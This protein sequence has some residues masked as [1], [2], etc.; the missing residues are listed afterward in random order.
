MTVEEF[1]PW[2][3]SRSEREHYDLVSGEVVAL[4]SE[5]AG[6]ARLKLRIMRRLAEAIEKSGVACEAFPNWMAVKV[7]S[8]TLYHPDALVRC[9]GR[10]PD[11]ALFV[12]DPVVLVDVR[13][14]LS[15]Y[16]D[17]GIKLGDSFR[18]P[19]LRHYLI[20]DLKRRTIIHH[21]RDAAGA[22]TTRIVR[23][24]AV[25]LDPPGIDLADIFEE[26]P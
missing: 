22:I 25:R 15:G 23:D 4:G 2:A 18:I 9:G 11:E 8:D 16:V 13:L 6:R 1:I 14:P 17:T 19:A 7:D 3:M 26:E 10:L 24:G 20:V 21:E 12:T 5:R